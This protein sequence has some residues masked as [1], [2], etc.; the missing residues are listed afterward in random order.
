M[1]E[2]SYDDLDRL[3][4]IREGLDSGL[5][6]SFEYVGPGRDLLTTYGNGALLDKR[7]PL[8]NQTNTGQSAGY[9]TNGRHLRHEWKSGLG[10]TITSYVNSYNGA[11][12]VGTDR[13]VEEVREHLFD[14]TDT[15]TFDSAYRM[16]GFLRDGT[17]ASTRTL[18]GADKMTSFIDEG[19][20]KAPVLD[21][22]PGMNQYA[23]FAGS[24]RTYDD[25]SALEDDGNFIF[26]H[27]SRDRVVEVRDGGGVVVARYG[28]TA[29]GRRV[30]RALGP[31]ASPTTRYLYAGSA[32][33]EERDAANTVLRQ[34]VDGR[35][36]GEHIQLLDHSTVAP[37][38]AVPLFY[39]SNSQGSVGALTD[40]LGTPVEHYEYSWL[41]RPRVLAD[42]VVSLPQSFFGN[43]YLF[44]GQRYDPEAETGSELNG[45]YFHGERYYSPQTGEYITNDAAGNW[46]GGQGNGY[47]AFGGDGW[48]I[49]PFGGPSLEEV[50]GPL[51]EDE[52]LPPE[53]FGPSYE[54]FL[55][56][57]FPT[58][59]QERDSDPRDSGLVATDDY[60][61]DAL[62]GVGALSLPAPNTVAQNEFIGLRPHNPIHSQPRGTKC[63][64]CDP[65][66]PAPEDRPESPR[67]DDPPRLGPGWYDLSDYPRGF[68]HAFGVFFAGLFD[69][70]K[71]SDNDSCI[72]DLPGRFFPG[73]DEHVL[74]NPV[75]PDEDPFIWLFPLELD[76]VWPV[77]PDEDPLIW[78]F[79]LEPGD[80]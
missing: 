48:N 10:A 57:R 36:P 3:F 21:G 6:A 17:V 18:D 72:V 38:Q 76:D 70:P 9:D 45:L 2:R 49:H 55:R 52:F 37:P 40:S 69:L 79:P 32:V 29:D 4:E 77:G 1:V 16:T 64:F 39:H 61:N 56:G 50:L 74:V 30:L 47:G 62:G 60:V 24:P 80:E 11:L 23:S 28:Y 51:R 33:L 15:Y 31:G 71:S 68:G 20:S 14:H 13:R 42:L 73:A 25:A 12:G 58:W 46:N 26:V 41:G 66:E 27:D 75:G 65:P 43:P 44:Q 63:P 5:I 8:T 35:G 54:E 22:A 53:V 78:P 34:F 67:L 19:A 59:A 7:D